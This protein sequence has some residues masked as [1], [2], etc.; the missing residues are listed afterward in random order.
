MK[1]ELRDKITAQALNEIVFARQHKQ[2]RIKKWQEVED[3]YLNKKVKSE[4]SRANVN[5]GQMQSFVHTLLSKIDNPLTFKF[6]K[7][8]ASQINRVNRL[9]SL[10]EYDSKRD[11][12]D[13][14][15]I[16][17]KKQGVMYGRAVYA[18]YADSVDG[19]QPHLEPVDIYDFLIDPS[20]GGIDI[21]KAMFMGRW[22]VVKTK[23]Q[24]KDGVKSGKY[25]RNE[26]NSLITGV[27]T[28]QDKP[29]E[30]LNKRNRTFGTGVFTPEKESDVTEKY[31]F[32]EWFTTFEGERYY[33]LLSEKGAS[34]IRIEK[35][36]DV[37]ESNLYPFWT[38]ACFPDMTEFWTLGYCEY[39]LDLFMA[40]TVSINQMLDNSEQIN[41]PQKIVDVT[42]IEDLAELKYRKD[43]FI[44]TKN[45]QNAVKFVETPPISGPIKVFELL[46]LIQEKSS[47]VTAS[48]KGIA[49]E[50]KVGIY[51]GNQANTADRFGLLNKSY[52]FGYQRF[53]MLYEH[54]VKEHLK[55]KIAV[56][57]L[58]PDGISLEEVSKRDIY[59]KDDTFGVMV[60]ASNAELALSEFEKR[61]KIAFLQANVG[62]PVQNPKKAYEI[63]ASIAGYTDDEIRQLMDVQEFGDAELISEAERD[64]EM[65][66]DG[67]TIKPN[68]HANLAYKQKFVDYMSDHEEDIDEETFS[69]LVVY[70]R[71]LDLIIQKNLGRQLADEQLKLGQGGG[72]LPQ[73]MSVPPLNPEA[74]SPNIDTNEPIQI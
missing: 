42:L 14:K 8:K 6:Y 45:S 74:L 43:G 5:L 52:S 59:W 21:E 28:A 11:N 23:S 7:R 39:A 58:G 24:L 10:K 16:V 35:L 46:D 22:G 4:E 47:G 54:G 26:T 25:L 29:Q 64:I 69:R 53:A 32:W 62:N 13:I 40:Q 30:E 38:W 48:A 60:E 67:K 2:G 33:I 31:K 61:S 56:D 73:Q 41:K 66:I 51:E 44:R 34:A 63:Q 9:N 50:D 15:D 71:S 18:Y 37:F 72:E 49:D 55:K 17:G 3:F 27:S 57:I 65:I 68:Q 70:I 12:W 20:A 36:S 1:K 19:Y